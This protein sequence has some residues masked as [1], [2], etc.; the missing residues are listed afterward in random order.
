[1]RGGLVQEGDA[2]PVMLFFDAY[3][4][5]VDDV[6]FRGGDRSSIFLRARPVRELDGLVDHCRH[7]LDTRTLDEGLELDN[8]S[9]A[10]AGGPGLVWNHDRVHEFFWPGVLDLERLL[11]LEG[12]WAETAQDGDGVQGMEFSVRETGET[13]ADN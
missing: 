7:R 4:L 6:V 2:I 8:G 3:S 13:R 1:M 11:V 9:D 10:V 5:S 12:L